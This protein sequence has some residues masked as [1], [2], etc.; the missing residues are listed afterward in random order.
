VQ[1]Q[2]LHTEQPGHT[3]DSDTFEVCV[4][5][6]RGGGFRCVSAERGGTGW[7]WVLACSSRH[8]CGIG[9]AKLMWGPCVFLLLGRIDTSRCALYSYCRVLY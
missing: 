2:C 1:I 4:E 8:V 5:G 7:V 9:C 3:V 6:P